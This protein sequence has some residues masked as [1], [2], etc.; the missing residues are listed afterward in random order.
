MGLPRPSLILCASIP[1]GTAGL[2]RSFTGCFNTQSATNSADTQTASTIRLKA[3]RVRRGLAR[4][5]SGDFGNSNGGN[6]L[7]T[8]ALKN[9][10]YSRSACR[11]AGESIGG[12]ELAFIDW[13]RLLQPSD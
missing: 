11:S 8:T 13:V 3:S 1:S 10:R 5:G 2:G 12:R 7:G 9:A 6:G 4:T